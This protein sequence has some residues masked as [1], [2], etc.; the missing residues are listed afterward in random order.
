MKNW[1]RTTMALSALIALLAVTG[2]GKL[3]NR[4]GDGEY[5]DSDFS[6]QCLYGH[7]YLIRVTGG[8][9]FAPKFDRDSG[10]PEKC[11]S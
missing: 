2:C 5:K 8:Q 9:Y 7:K 11:D 1:K 10:L 3:P 4:V 6:V